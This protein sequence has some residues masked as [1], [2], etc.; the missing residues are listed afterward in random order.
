MADILHIAGVDECQSIPIISNI[1]KEK[2]IPSVI[3]TANY[4]TALSVT[5]NLNYFLDDKKIVTLGEEDAHFLKYDASSNENLEAFQDAKLSLLTRAGAVVVAPISAAVYNTDTPEDFLESII[6]LSVGQNIDIDD[7]LRRLTEYGYARMHYTEVPGEFS[8]RGGIIDVFPIQSPDAIRIE[9]FDVQIESI[10]SFDADTQKTLVSLDNISILPIRAENDTK[11][12]ILDYLDDSGYIFIIDP[13]RI[14]SLVEI[15][16]QEYQSDYEQLLEKG[17]CSESDIALI[18]TTDDFFSILRKKNIALITTYEY[19]PENT[20][21]AIPSSHKITNI[22][23][24]AKQPAALYGQMDMLLSELKSYDRKGYK[25]EIVCTTNERLEKISGFLFDNNL[26]KNIELTIG[27]LT[28]GIELASEKKVFLWDGDIFKTK[29][30]SRRHKISGGE[31]ISDFADIEVGN[32]I[33][34]ERHGIGVYKG[35]R[36]MVVAGNSKD[37]LTIA[38]SGKDVLYIPVEQMSMIQKY[39]GTGEKKPKISRLGS[40]DWIRTKAR[41]RKEI[42]EYAAEILKI[43]AERKLASGHAFS[44]DSVWQKDFEDRFPYEPTNDQVRCFDSV[45]KDMEN[46][47]PMDRLICGD[48]GYGKTE[49]ALRAVFKCVSDSK[50]ALVLVPTTILAAQHYQTFSERFEDFPVSVAML[51]RFQTAAEQKEIIS[52]LKDGSIDIVIGTHK[53]LSSK[54]VFKDLGLLV[55]DEEQRFGVKHKEK[56]RSLKAGVDILTLTATPIPRTLHMSLLGIRDLELL[57]EPPEDRFP[58]RT[59]V[60]EER[61][62]VIAESIRRELDRG[63]QVFIVHNRIQDIERIAAWINELVP[64]ASVAVCHASMNEKVIDETM[65]GFVNGDSNVLICTTIIESG[66]DIP[67]V[68]TIIIMDAE[69]LGL[70]QLYQ[71][72]GRVGRT[73]RVAFAYLLYR[74]NKQLTETAQKR[75]QTIKEFTEFGSGFKIAMKDLE[76]RGAGNL[77]GVSQHGHLAS[78]GYDLYCKMMDDAIAALN[79]QKQFE[80]DRQECKLELNIPAVIPSA[81]IEDEVVKLQIYKRISSISSDEEMIDVLNEINDR[82]GSVPKSVENLV[83][84]SY[85][86]YLADSINLETLTSDSST[87]VKFVYREYPEDFKKIVYNASSKFVGMIE[88]DMRAVPMIIL[89]ISTVPVGNETKIIL[90]LLKKIKV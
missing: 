85:I 22:S 45:K 49:V 86:K 33:V 72:R 5:K 18:P 75:L 24:D 59:Y 88:I 90:E 11:T 4:G 55:I 44:K 52:K 84:I 9:L 14:E 26:T 23:Y 31:K 27:E 54:I 66:L 6:T 56:I 40:D 57:A 70:T 25:I 79:G 28:S 74:K 19:L 60:S 12:T 2:A 68:N 30:K 73:N 35:I 15:Q 53:L 37:Y 47:Y 67:N 42:E 64:T 32:Y 77:L 61:D 7:F 71:L 50:Q 43:S 65:Y 82:F 87:K 63:G 8:V 13:G 41:V 62:D 78:V 46:P 20:V 58:V 39:I 29:K 10:R 76:I 17:E 21:N 83:Y 48:V 38:Y 81:Y 51:T 80:I 1:I 69:R 3:I 16:A 36:N 34:H 89:D